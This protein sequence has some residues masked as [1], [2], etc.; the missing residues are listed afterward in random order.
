MDLSIII[1]NWNSTDFLQ[2][3]V[4]S[5]RTHTSGI[6]YEII[7]V[8]NASSAEDAARLDSAAGDTVVIRLREN[9]GFARANNVGFLRSSGEYALFLNPDTKLT[10]PAINIMMEGI[11]ALPD[12]GIVGCR[13]LNAD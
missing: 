8:D 5:I 2:E 3:A 1:V 9:L 13:L 11:E 10:G 6:R 4:A 12:A 7:V